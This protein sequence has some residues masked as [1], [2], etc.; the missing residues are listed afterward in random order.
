[1]ISRGKC[2][3]FYT[4][5]EADEVLGVVFEI[6]PAEKT[7]LDKAEGLGRGYHDE[8]VQIRTPLGQLTA[9]AYIADP[10]YIDDSMIIYL[11]RGLHYVTIPL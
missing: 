4:G 1:M 5:N 10:A 6:D 2:N 11:T 3:A 9:C 8:P 7:D